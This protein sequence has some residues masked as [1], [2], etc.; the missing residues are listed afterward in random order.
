MSH[1]NVSQPSSFKI[2]ISGFSDAGDIHEKR[3]PTP[4]PS[5]SLSLPWEAFPPL[6]MP[7]PSGL[8]TE[9]FEKSCS[10]QSLFSDGYP[11]CVA[12]TLSWFL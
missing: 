12:V 7:E 1:Q 2:P 8:G 4:S 5:E 3:F 11:F 6:Y 9:V 10:Q